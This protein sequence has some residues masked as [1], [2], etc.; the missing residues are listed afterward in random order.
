MAVFGRDLPGVGI[1]LFASAM[2]CALLFDPTVGRSS[3]NDAAPEPLSI[4][5]NFSELRDKRR[6]LR[7]ALSEPRLQSIA[8]ANP[9]P[10][11]IPCG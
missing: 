9:E 8:E 2:P 10:E 4:S 5:Q 6:I 11:A 7:E 3:R 1:R